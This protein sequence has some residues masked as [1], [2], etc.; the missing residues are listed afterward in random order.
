MG[1]TKRPAGASEPPDT[2]KGMATNSHPWH[3]L[4]VARVAEILEVDSRQGLSEAEVARRLDHHGFNSL[5]K[6]K[7]RAWWQRLVDQFTSPLIYVLAAAALVTFVL[8]DYIDTVVILIV[9][10][11]NATI[12]FIQE[13]RAEK[14]LDAVRG[15]LSE[16]ATVVRSGQRHTIDA[17]LLVPGDIVIVES[18]DDVP[19]DLRIFRANNVTINE[20]ALTG[21]SVAQE[22]S[23][24]AVSDVVIADRTNMAYAGTVV[25]SGVAYGMVVATGSQTELGTIGRLVSSVSD[26]KT[27]LTT[28]L[29][30][31]SLQ[32]TFFILT[33]G[34]AAFAWGVFVRSLPV[35]EAFLAVVA[36]SVAAIPEGLPRW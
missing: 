28:R 25:A 21:E 5:P 2:L 17:S 27:P 14:A 20:G 12:G 9:V 6:E 29:H 3:Q 8:E 18:G 23:T 36:L 22:K 34:A 15:L 26:V 7:S 4:E 24:D 35:G 30:H 10:V 31:F 32:V 19:A 1:E 16:K 33:L 11:A 13:G